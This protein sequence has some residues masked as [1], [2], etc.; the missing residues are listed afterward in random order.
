[1]LNIGKCVLWK[2]NSSN[3]P[4]IVSFCHFIHFFEFLYWNGCND[5]DTTFDMNLRQHGFRVCYAFLSN[6]WH[7]FYHNYR[8]S[9]RIFCD[10]WIER[11]EMM[12]QMRIIAKWGFWNLCLLTKLVQWFICIYGGYKTE[13]KVT[14]CMCLWA[15]Y[16]TVKFRLA[17]AQ[18]YT[19]S[20]HIYIFRAMKKM[21]P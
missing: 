5:Y 1:M 16:E 11:P 12:F 17:W 15:E 2:S 7:V 18:A 14:K 6:L 20:V 9:D 19:T 21:W 8:M 4:Y 13:G 10:K 3:K